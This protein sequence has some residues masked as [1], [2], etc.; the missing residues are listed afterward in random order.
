MEDSSPQQPQPPPP[1]PQGET[2]EYRAALV[3]LI[4]L[5]PP[6]ESQDWVGYLDCAREAERLTYVFTRRNDLKAFLKDA[7]TSSDIFDK[8]VTFRSVG[9]WR[10]GFAARV[11]DERYRRCLRELMAGPEDGA[12]AAKAMAFADSLLRPPPRF[13]C[14]VS[15]ALHDDR[16]LARRLIA[17]KS[18]REDGGWLKEA[19]RMY[20]FMHLPILEST[21]RQKNTALMCEL[22]RRMHGECLHYSVGCEVFHG[23]DTK[24][25]VQAVKESHMRVMW[26][27]IINNHRLREEAR[28]ADPAVQPLDASFYDLVLTLE[29]CNTMSYSHHNDVMTALD[30]VVEMHRDGRVSKQQLDDFRDRLFA[31]ADRHGTY[32]AYRYLV[33]ESTRLVERRFAHAVIPFALAATEDRKRRRTGA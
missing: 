16:W 28:R 32:L 1:P 4:D 30:C 29:Y 25:V 12:W 24:H 22:I 18:Q 23:L 20:S 2:C 14:I 19:Y 10:K 33:E 8:D 17:M 3:A 7:V 13:R 21:L 11:M 9:G 5:P 27:D 15:V 31:M 26:S 6:G